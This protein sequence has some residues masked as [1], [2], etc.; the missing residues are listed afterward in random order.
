M[1][2]RAVGP[3]HSN[4]N[5]LFV[6]PLWPI[7]LAIDFQEDDWALYRY[8]TEALSYEAVDSTLGFLRD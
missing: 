8:S 2:S 5:I 4:F 3:I 6:W 1:V 7:A